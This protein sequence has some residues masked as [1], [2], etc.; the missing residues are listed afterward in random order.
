MQG[1]AL[2]SWNGRWAPFLW[3]E[4]GGGPRGGGGRLWVTPTPLKPP[5]PF[6][7]DGWG[8]EVISRFDTALR[9]AG[10]FYT[11]SNG[12]QILERRWDPQKA[13]CQPPKTPLSLMEPPG[14]PQ[15]PIVPYGTPCPPKKP[16]YPL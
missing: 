9:T 8:K 2:W 16:H 11:D 1:G 3:G 4:R 5:S 14:P 10:R 12:R 15:N 7:R 13:P 6:H